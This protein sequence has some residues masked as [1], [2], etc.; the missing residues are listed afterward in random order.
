[1]TR[2]V[3]RHIQEG[4]R[5]TLATAIFLELVRIVRHG[6]AA[7]A[8]TAEVLA[9]AFPNIFLERGTMVE[10]ALSALVEGKPRPAPPQGSR[11]EPVSAAAQALREALSL[12]CPRNILRV[13]DR[14]LSDG[15]RGEVI[16]DRAALD[17]MVLKK[18]RTTNRGEAD[19]KDESAFAT[20][21]GLPHETDSPLFE[22]RPAFV[23]AWARRTRDKAPDLYGWSGSL[24]ASMCKA[25]PKVAKD[26]AWLASRPPARWA[27]A[28]AAN[29]A[30][31]ETKGALIPK[32][33]GTT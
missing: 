18:F 12:G 6:P 21:A 33:D 5:G 26:L 28:S 30:W 13:L 23:R 31:R 25:S 27:S 2:G 1:M 7:A 4:S 22:V 19:P 10:D 20:A 32:A 17:S 3:R 15:P 9:V 8:E 14:D 16:V 29:S 11:V 24:V